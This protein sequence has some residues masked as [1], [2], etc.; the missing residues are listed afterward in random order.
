MDELHVFKNQVLVGRYEI[1]ATEL[2]LGRAGH[3]VLESPNVSRIHA[4]LSFYPE[5]GYVV[6][7]LGSRNGLKVN[8]NSVNEYELKTN[9]VVELADYQIR[10]RFTGQGTIM[11]APP[12]A[13]RDGLADTQEFTAASISLFMQAAVSADHPA[14]ERA[15]SSRM[16]RV[17][18]DNPK[19]PT[20]PKPEA[21]KPEAAKPAAAKPEPAKDVGAKPADAA[22]ADDKKPAD[23]KPAD[24]KPADA[25]KKDDK[26]ADA[27]KAD[28]KK[29][30]DKKPADA[31]KKDEKKPADAAA[32][33]D[34]KKADEKKPADAAKK[35]EK[36]P[37]EPKKEVA[38]REAVGAEVKKVYDSYFRRL[39]RLARADAEQPKADAKPMFSD[40]AYPK[41]RHAWRVALRYSWLLACLLSV[42]WMGAVMF[43][44]KREVFTS[45]SVSKGHEIFGNE[46]AK[47][48]VK[49]FS[50]VV[51]D[52]ACLSC[53][54]GLLTK[55]Q[56][57][58]LIGAQKDRWSTHAMNEKNTPGCA[59]CHVEHGGHPILARAV[60]DLSCT[61]CHGDLA[62][63]VTSAGLAIVTSGGRTI[64][65]LD[66]HVEF[67]AV[68]RNNDTAAL[69][70]NHARHL[71]H[72]TPAMETPGRI[73]WK[74]EKGRDHI[75]C[76]D[77]HE[78][79]GSRKYFKPITYARHCAPCH[80]TEIV[81][82][83]GQAPTPIPH[84]VPA[85]VLVSHVKGMGIEGEVKKKLEDYIKDHP[86]DLEAS[87]GGPGPKRPPGQPAPKPKTLTAEEWVEKKLGSWRDNV[88]SKIVDDLLHAEAKGGCAKCHKLEGPEDAQNIVP[89]KVPA[90]WF[91]NGQ[92]NHEKHRVVSCA[93][94]H[95][96]TNGSAV[97]T[98]V[99]L[100]GVESCRNCHRAG[101]ASSNCTLCHL[102]HDRGSERRDM[103]GRVS[104]A[105]LAPGF[106]RKP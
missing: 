92:F 93:E 44:E 104:R 78:P 100:P 74:K 12:I 56:F 97:T 8:G 6:T 59:M 32:K 51:P 80:P 41:K 67:A 94:C 62:A 43:R 31:A 36:K 37:A 7:D 26:P 20:P 14:L 106:E 53:H 42:G 71:E 13:P 88:G 64:A 52:G 90:R 2:V 19:P 83:A 84:G 54:D 89:T 85:Q 49:P 9:D 101:G 82:D 38:K 23:A 76:S 1:H 33:K 47:C 11:R 66:K 48:H 39:K 99:L 34:D 86:K 21:K 81:K 96:K 77:C 98:D 18:D 75:E 87:G 73:A 30:D 15:A 72:P 61:V 55:G 46:C 65:S 105:E 10:C 95:P 50:L 63:N 91:A 70:L 57:E 17:A 4:L 79:D 28:D 22:K 3:I 103:N 27:A 35:D 25:A 29:P 60:T 58:E 69:S 68:V 102:Y 24:A 45:E 40:L 5:R 16:G